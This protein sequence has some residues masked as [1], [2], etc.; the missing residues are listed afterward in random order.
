MA[1]PLSIAA[2]VA[3]L[4]SLAE[5]V[6]RLGYQYHS[7]VKGFL[8]DFER[9]LSEIFSLYGIL[10][11]IKLIVSRPGRTSNISFHKRFR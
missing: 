6:I 2:S 10:C 1:D 4:I 5:T 8:A 3:G 9:L 11:Q 7:D